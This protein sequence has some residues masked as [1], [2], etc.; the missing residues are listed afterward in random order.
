M[1]AWV[2]RARRAWP[3]EHG[4]PCALHPSR[5][6]PQAL[7]LSHVLSISHHSPHPLFYPFLF[8]RTQSHFRGQE[9]LS[10]HPRGLFSSQQRSVL[11]VSHETPA[12]RESTQN[13]IHPQGHTC[14][15]KC[16][17]Q[18][19]FCHCDTIPKANKRGKGW[20]WLVVSEFG[21]CLVLLF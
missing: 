11:P 15:L 21:C 9:Y 6:W 3:A 19:A 12:V 1:C 13:H 17:H 5:L 16:L 2:Q 8:P 10:A 4:L 20:F 7:L 18:S 14:P